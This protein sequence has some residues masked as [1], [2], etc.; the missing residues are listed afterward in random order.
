[1][2]NLQIRNNIQYSAITRLWNIYASN[3][4]RYPENHAFIIGD[5]IAD[6]F[7]MIATYTTD[8][9]MVSHSDTLACIPQCSKDQCWLLSYLLLTERHFG[10]ILFSPAFTQDYIWQCTENW[11]MSSQGHNL[12]HLWKVMEVRGNLQQLEKGKCHIHIQKSP[13]GSCWE[14]QTSQPH[15]GAWEN[16]EGSP[17]GE[18]SGHMKNKKVM[19]NSQCGFTKDVSCLNLWQNGWIC[20]WN[21]WI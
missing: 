1:M 15:L 19:R 13:K 10:T 21:H 8:K 9:R 4:H 18:I 2:V 17:L 3:T 12:Y 14:V 16:H 5:K 20:E 7:P 11:P 6:F